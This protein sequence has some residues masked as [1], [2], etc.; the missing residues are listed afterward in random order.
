MMQRVLLLSALFALTLN[1]SAQAQGR[2]FYGFHSISHGHAKIGLSKQITYPPDDYY[3]D[4]KGGYIEIFVA[5][6]QCSD[7]YRF[8]WEFDQDIA[9]MEPGFVYKATVTGE[10]IEGTCKQ[11]E[12]W[13]QLLGS[14]DN[15]RLC[16][17]NALAGPSVSIAVKAKGDSRTYAV[18]EDYNRESNYEISVSRVAEEDVRIFLSFSCTTNPSPRSNFDYQVVYNYKKNYQPATGSVGFD[19]QMLYGIGTNMA[20]LEKAAESDADYDALSEFLNEAI[21][22]VRASNCLDAD[23]L[24]HLKKRMQETPENSK[25]Y[26]EEIKAYRE[27]LPELIPRDCIE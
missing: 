24:K 25:A 21:N 15:C 8:S 7:K 2:N 18:P 23:Y 4:T 1:F 9:K 19:C 16:T 17:D 13:A 10:R 5:K 11:N 26:Y 22:H 12:A 14:N 20:F 3:A 27:Q 6:G